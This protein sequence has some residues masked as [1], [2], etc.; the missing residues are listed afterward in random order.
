MLVVLHNVVAGAAQADDNTNTTSPASGTCWDDALADALVM[1][2]RSI[3][4]SLV[5]NDMLIN[6][7]HLRG[8][9]I[10]VSASAVICV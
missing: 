10:E 4:E 2:S 8:I 6:A 3:R 9:A 7:E 1:R 5:S